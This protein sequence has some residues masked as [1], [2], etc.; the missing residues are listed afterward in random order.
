M[1]HMP[2][3]HSPSCAQTS[4]SCT[5]YDDGPQWPLSHFAEQQSVSALHELPSVLQVALSGAHVPLVHV[6]PQH[7]PSLVQAP[8]SD[9]HWVAEQMLPTQLSVQQSV[10]AEHE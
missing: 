6:P 5:Q 9:T 7:S 3:Q 2:P 10:F 8:L 4:P 1:S